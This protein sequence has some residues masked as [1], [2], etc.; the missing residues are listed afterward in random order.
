M[1]GKNGIDIGK[2]YWQQSGGALH[3]EKIHFDGHT[4]GQDTIDIQK[5]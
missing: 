4:F 3:G 1:I 5:N 2:M